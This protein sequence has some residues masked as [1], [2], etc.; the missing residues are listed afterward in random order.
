MHVSSKLT[1]LPLPMLLVFT[2]YVLN[3]LPIVQAAAKIET[4][5]DGPIIGIFSSYA[6]RNDGG[7]TIHSKG[8]MESFGILVDDR[9]QSLGGLQCIITNEGYVVPLHIHNGLPCMDMSPPSDVDL[10]RYPHVFFC[11]DSPW[12]PT[13]LDNEFSSHDFTEPAIAIDRRE[14]LDP[15]VNDFG[16]VAVHELQ[17]DLIVSIMSLVA[18]SAFAMAVAALSAFPQQ[19]R[20]RLPDLDV[21]RPHFGWVPVDRIQATLDATTQYYRATIHHPFRK[22]FKSRFPAA[23]VRRLP[24]WFSTDTIFSSV[25]AHDDGIPGHGGCTMLQVYGG[26]ESHFLAGYPLASESDMHISFE[27]FICQYGAPVGL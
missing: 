8:Q 4:V 16:C 23:N 9:A 27:D 22:H 10:E 24:E 21:L 3:S 20:P 11:S 2:D 7:R 1:L 25:P 13:V 18:R 26:I 17:V 15:R 19:L 14:S 6:Q 5:A 12:D